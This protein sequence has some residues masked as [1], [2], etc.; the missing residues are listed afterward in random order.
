M[1]D[2]NTRAKMVATL[3]Q[4]QSRLFDR[5]CSSSGFGLVQYAAAH[6]PSAIGIDAVLEPGPQSTRPCD[7]FLSGPGQHA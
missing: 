6:V 1:G 4:R 3:L 7:V 2:K 5:D